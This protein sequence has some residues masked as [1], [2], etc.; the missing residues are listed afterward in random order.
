MR[1]DSIRPHF[2]FSTNLYSFHGDLLNLKLVNIGGITKNIN[3]NNK[4]I[5]VEPPQR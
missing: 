2:S 4:E 5:L 3:L 1:I